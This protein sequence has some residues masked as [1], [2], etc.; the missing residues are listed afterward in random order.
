[1]V[2]FVAGLKEGALLLKIYSLAAFF[3]AIGFLVVAVGLYGNLKTAAAAEAAEEVT[4][5]EP[6]PPGWNSTSVSC[7]SS[8]HASP[9][10]CVV[11]SLPP[12]NVYG[13]SGTFALLTRVGGGGAGWL[14]ATE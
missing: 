4:A 10:S 3:L 11:S 7:S 1:M 12:W 2:G 14:V 13:V 6:P 5:H 8:S 9:Q